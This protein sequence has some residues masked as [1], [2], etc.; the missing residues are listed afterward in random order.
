MR[1]FNRLVVIALTILALFFTIVFILL[2]E[3]VLAVL[4]AVFQFL[5]SGTSEYNTGQ[6]FWFFAAARV[7]VGGVVVLICLLVL[8]LEVRR[9]R[10]R[11]I[12]A[13]KLAGGEAN[14]TIES[15]A[16][17]V[18]YHIDQLTDVV[19]VAPRI[20]G[21]SRGVDIDLLLETSPEIDVPMK[22]EEVMQ[23]TKEVVEDRMGLKL[24]K[25]TINIKHAP[26]PEA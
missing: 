15:I 3:Q 24:G 6:D 26:Y 14:I 21:R 16:Q 18:A 7:I 19:R 11:T 1:V 22:T 2:P 20:T 10:K 4:V 8:W 12:Q 25:V 17:R 9:P 13:Q 23:V 5:H